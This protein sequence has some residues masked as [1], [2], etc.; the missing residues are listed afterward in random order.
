MALNAYIAQVRDL[1]HD[2]NGQMWSN[3]QL[4][5]YI[6]IARNR[7][8]QDTK[9]LRQIIPGIPLVAGTEAY[10]IPALS[11]TYNLPIIDVMGID[12]YYGTVR[13]ALFYFAWTEFSARYRGWSTLTRQPEAFTR[14]GAL[15][16]F[17]G[18]N[19]DQAYLT[20]W[21]CAVNPAP[22]VNDS[23]PELIP[24]PFAEVIRFW[25]CY[26]AKFYQQAYGEGGR[27]K[28]EYLQWLLMTN[29]AFNTRTIVNPYAAGA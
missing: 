14:M 3:T 28:G 6:N 20:D 29:R 17:L 12:L 5:N 4:T 11:S 13:R 25:A 10:S 1:L 2:P 24:A 21:I 27:F 18:P 7:V 8:A 16:V 26:E 15:Q 9:C 19:P 22:L 23:T